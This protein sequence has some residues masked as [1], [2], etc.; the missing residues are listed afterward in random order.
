M[1][2]NILL[3]GCLFGLVAISSV[4]QSKVIVDLATRVADDAMEG[5]HKGVLHLQDPEQHSDKHEKAIMD[6]ATRVVDDAMTGAHKGVLH[7]QEPNQ[8]TNKHEEVIRNAEYGDND[9]VGLSQIM[10]HA[11]LL[12]EMVQVLKARE[13]GPAVELLMKLFTHYLGNYLNYD[14]NVH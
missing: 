11:R 8:Q 13:V 10:N 5:A 12:A 3:L 14:N 1:K 9:A 7:Q 4:A 2:T 6:L